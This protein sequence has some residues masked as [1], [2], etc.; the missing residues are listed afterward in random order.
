MAEYLIQDKTLKYIF[1]AVKEKAG[2]S[3]T[4]MDTERLINEIYLLDT[5]TDIGAP[6]DGVTFY[7]YDGTVL[8]HYTVKEARALTSL[9]AF[10][11][12]MPYVGVAFAGWT[13]S[14][15]EVNSVVTSLDVGAMYESNN[16]KFVLEIP[17]SQ[18]IDFYFKQTTSNGVSITWGDGNVT[19]V[20]GTGDVCASH[21]YTS[22]GTYTVEFDIISGTLQ[23]VTQGKYFMD[24]IT[25]STSS[26]KGTRQDYL[27]HAVIGG[28][29]IFGEPIENIMYSYYSPFVGSFY[30][31]T[32]ILSKEYAYIPQHAFNYCQSLKFFIV[33]NNV[34]RICKRAFYCCK[35]IKG[36]VIP[37]SVTHIS[38]SSVIFQCDALIKLIFPSNIVHKSSL[39]NYC[40]NLKWLHVRRKT[41]CNYSGT[42]SLFGDDNFINNNLKIYVPFTCVEA[43]KT[44]NHW[45]DY[46]SRIKGE[47]IPVKY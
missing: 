40:K 19:T 42:I 7:D 27:K 8:Y 37:E 34:T 1:D 14:L 3:S 10:P 24:V 4:Q 22:G 5:D 44:A 47:A 32:V 18:T 43:Y 17:T 41:P 25:S 39:F 26:G 20:S 9:P 29:A 46:A 2:I 45:S 33:P 13:H 36:I 15:D 11:K 35:A 12:E 6:A 16:S 30:L 31:E 21:A 23:F 28:G 38:D